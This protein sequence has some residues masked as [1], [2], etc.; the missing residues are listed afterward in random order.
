MI[1]QGRFTD[2]HD[3]LTSRGPEHLVAVPMNEVRY[4]TKVSGFL[5]IKSNER[6]RY[7]EFNS[8]SFLTPEH[9]WNPPHPYCP[10]DVLF[11]VKKQDDVEYQV[12]EKLL[13]SP[14]VVAPVEHPQSEE[15]LANNNSLG[16]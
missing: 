14:F 7:T 8:G 9:G 2:Q 12:L 3:T 4:L 6:N 10:E 11:S 15:L 16:G 1:I 13:Q 5:Y